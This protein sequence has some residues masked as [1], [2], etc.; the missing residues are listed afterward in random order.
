[1][2]KLQAEL[3]PSSAEIIRASSRPGLA[4]RTLPTRHIGNMT[5]AVVSELLRKYRSQNNAL[6]CHK[7]VTGLQ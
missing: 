2:R 1:M 6:T 4:P 7:P 3:R 5:V